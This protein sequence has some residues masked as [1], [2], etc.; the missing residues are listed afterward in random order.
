MAVR[1]TE[2]SLVR[3]E[4]NPLRKEGLFLLRLVKGSPPLLR[5]ADLFLVANCA[6]KSKPL[7]SSILLPAQQLK[8]HEEG[9][10]LLL[11]QLPLPLLVIAAKTSLVGYE[12]PIPQILKGF[13]RLI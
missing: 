7:L 10:V 13:L 2:K 9:G 5:E 4:R 12:L 11:L 6:Q 1:G 8:Y 3:Q